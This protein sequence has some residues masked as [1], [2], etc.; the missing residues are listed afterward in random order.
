MMV[1]ADRPTWRRVMRQ[2]HAAWVIAKK[3]ARI[4]YLKP[5]AEKVVRDLRRATRK[6]HS[7]E[8]KIRIVFEGLPGE[9][10]FASLRQREAVAGSLHYSRPKASLRAGMLGTEV[11]GTLPNED[12]VTHFIDAMR[13]RRR[14][15]GRPAPQHE[16]G[17]ARNHQRCS[18]RRPAGR[19]KLAKAIAAQPRRPLKLAAHAANGPAGMPAWRSGKMS[20]RDGRRRAQ[21]MLSGPQKGAETSLAGPSW[22][23]AAS[24]PLIYLVGAVRIRTYDP[25]I[26]SQLLYQLS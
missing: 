1:R 16:P 26:K 14:M 9:E 19:G 23:G 6:H 7:A 12:A 17:A 13:L 3:D 20:R 4:Y 25:L 2:A 8:D 21:V 15:N 18:E 10:S 24:K 11:V 22:T 5:P